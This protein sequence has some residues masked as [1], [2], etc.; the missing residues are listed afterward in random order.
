MSLFVIDC[1]ENYS[2]RAQM[3]KAAG[4][5]GVIRYFNPLSNGKDSGKSLT[6][7]EVRVWSSI[8]MAVG[9]VVEGYG[10][11][12][13]TG[14]DGPSG[15]RDA[16][17]VLAWLPS[18]GLNPSPALVVYFAVD[19]DASASQINGDEVAYFDNI[20]SVFNTSAP[21]ARPRVGIYGS[22][23][24]CMSMIGTK[25]ADEGWVA[26]STGWAHYKDYVA[27]NGWRLLQ[28]ITANEMWNGINADVDT[29]NGTLAD[30]GLMVPFSAPRAYVPSPPKAAAPL[31]G[32]TPAPKKGV[33]QSVLDSFRGM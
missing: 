30:A 21:A 25:R 14:V 5:A 11:A 23:W 17:E 1:A 4:C 29:V 22:G 6:V 27:A 3:I 2:K 20:R 16:K 15:I 19:T 31:P 33:F 7:D 8:G 13:G 10:M 12:N 24:S 9:V 32:P 28:K 26:G 18:V